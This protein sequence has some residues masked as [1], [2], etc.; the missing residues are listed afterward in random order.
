MYMPEPRYGLAAAICTFLPFPTCPFIPLKSFRQARYQSP[1]EKLD[2]SEG[3][4][5]SS[6]ELERALQ[7]EGT[8]EMACPRQ[9]VS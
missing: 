5:V 1:A 8:L 7:T 4:A 3:H 6:C 2:V 9:R